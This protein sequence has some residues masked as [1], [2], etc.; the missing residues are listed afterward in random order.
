[1][2]TDRKKTLCIRSGEV[3]RS[4]SSERQPKKTS[5]RQRRRKRKKVVAEDEGK[6][7]MEEEMRLS[8]ET[9]PGTPRWSWHDWYPRNDDPLL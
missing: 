8:A 6:D 5:A 2:E 3:V 4:E 1:M 9:E 7:K